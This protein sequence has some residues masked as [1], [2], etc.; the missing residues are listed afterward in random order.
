MI[1]KKCGGLL[2]K[3]SNG[4]ELMCIDCLARFRISEGVSP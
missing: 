3:H 2:K 1:C 4:K